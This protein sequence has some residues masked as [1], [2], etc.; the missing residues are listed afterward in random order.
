MTFMHISHVS[1]GYSTGGLFSKRHRVDVLRDLNLDLHE[2]QS[3]GLLGASG[4]GK[5]V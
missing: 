4:S 2:G 5:S 1:H 3:L